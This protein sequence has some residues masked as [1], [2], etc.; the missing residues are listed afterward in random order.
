MH[1]DTT[2]YTEKSLIF[3]TNV[4]III[5]PLFGTYICYF[6]IYFGTKT[7]NFIL[8]FKTNIINYI[9]YFETIDYLCNINLKLYRLCLNDK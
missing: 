7:I 8:Y 4:T 3:R 1:I 2:D 5:Y 9:L 6:I